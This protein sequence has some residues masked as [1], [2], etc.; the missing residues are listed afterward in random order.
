MVS[1][2]LSGTLRS[3]SCQAKVIRLCSKLETDDGIMWWGEGSRTDVLK[4]QWKL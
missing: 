3:E 1:M 4:P 2:L